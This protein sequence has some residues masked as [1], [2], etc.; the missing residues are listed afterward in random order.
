ME[1]QR[2]DSGEG[3]PASSRSLNLLDIELKIIVIV[4][5]HGVMLRP[6]PDPWTATLARGE[7]HGGVRN[8]DW[9][10]AGPSRRPGAGVFAAGG[11]FR[12]GS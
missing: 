6:T 8:D 4:V 5:R 3:Y 12:E 7:L 1:R 10:P 11:F 9:P 2:L